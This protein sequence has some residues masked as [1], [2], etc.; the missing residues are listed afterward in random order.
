LN[1]G[2]GRPK[3]LPVLATIC[4][5]FEKVARGLAGREKFNDVDTRGRCYEIT[6]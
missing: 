3:E 6:I 2:E 4:I 1:P 5:R